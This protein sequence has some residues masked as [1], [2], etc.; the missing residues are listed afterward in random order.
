MFIT[1][2]KLQLIWTLQGAVVKD[3]VTALLLLLGWLLVLKFMSEIKLSKY[4]KV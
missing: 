4:S 3:R 1:F 2:T